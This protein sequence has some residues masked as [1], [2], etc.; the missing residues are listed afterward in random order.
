VTP[1]GQV[2]VLKSDWFGELQVPMLKVG[3]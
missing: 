3:G 1:E 2:I